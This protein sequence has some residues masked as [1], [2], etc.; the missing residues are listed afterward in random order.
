MKL[1]THF[2]L[3]LRLR[4]AELCLHCL[5][6]VHGMVLNSSSMGTTSLL[7]HVISVPPK[8]EN[9]IGRMF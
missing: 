3:M 2:N 8:E 4:M 1:T 9:F 7:Q 5:M 6:H